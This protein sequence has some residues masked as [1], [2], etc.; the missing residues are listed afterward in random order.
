MST[1]RQGQNAE[2]SWYPSRDLS[3]TLLI[4]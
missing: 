1:A 3:M 2:S 4:S